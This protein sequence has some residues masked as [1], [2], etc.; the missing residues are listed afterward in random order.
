[1]GVPIRRAGEGDRETVNRLLHEG[2]FRDPVS[3]WIFPEDDHRHAT[4]PVLMGAF[5]DTALTEGYVDMTEDGS[6]AALWLS[7][8]DGPHAP[9]DDSPARLRAAIDPANE[10]IEQVARLTGQAHPTHR[11]H[12]YLMLVAVSPAMHGTGLGTTLLTSALDRFDRESRAAYLEASSPRSRALYER[13]GFTFMGT[14]V[15][16]PGGPAMYP[17]WR[18]PRE[19]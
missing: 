18:D 1:M 15:D 13:L 8:P 3:N 5:L 9:D 17:M 11:P 19:V 12:E 14:T 16:L 6:A 7:V 10:R 2:F 4:H